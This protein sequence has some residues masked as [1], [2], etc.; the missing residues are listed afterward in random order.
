VKDLELPPV[1]TPPAKE[2]FSSAF[3]EVTLISQTEIV[4]TFREAM[5]AY[6]S[7]LTQD[8]NLA[9]KKAT[10]DTIMQMGGILP[11]KGPKGKEGSVSQNLFINGAKLDAN[12]PLGGM[13]KDLDDRMKGGEDGK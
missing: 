2:D 11:L 12:S 8:D 4:K 13:L 7:L 5:E 9:M 10:D 3:K 1:A 6:S